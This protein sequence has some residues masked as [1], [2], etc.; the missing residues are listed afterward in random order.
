MIIGYSAI[1]G[2]TD[3]PV[4]RAVLTD[5]AHGRRMNPPTIKIKHSIAIEIVLTWNRPLYRLTPDP[6]VVT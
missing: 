1:V 3:S 4:K 2:R 6:M 5:D